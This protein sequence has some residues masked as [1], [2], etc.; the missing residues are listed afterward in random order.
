MKMFFGYLASMMMVL[1]SLFIV[2]I[3]VISIINLKTMG[4]KGI[5]DVRDVSQSITCVD[6]TYSLESGMEDLLDKYSSFAMLIADNGEVVW[7]YAKPVEV[8]DHYD[9]KDVVSFARWYLKDYPV[10]TW[11]SDDGIVVLGLPKKTVWKYPLD[12]NMTTISG[13]MRS[14]PYIIIINAV[15]LILLP[16]L[17]TK[18][19]INLR[20]RSR[21]AWIAGVSH[22]IRTPLS[23]VLASVEKGSVAEKQC[24]KIRDLIGNLNTENK[25]DSGTGK[26]VDEKIALVPL[27]REIVCD[28]INSYGDEYTFEANIDESLGDFTVNADLSL[29]RRMIDN[30]ITNAVLHNDGGCT[31]QVTLEPIINRSKTRIS[32]AKL[33]VSDNGR[34]ADAGKI[35]ALNAGIKNNYLPEHGLGLRVVKEV[36]KKYRY[37]VRFSSNQGSFFK[38]EI[39][40]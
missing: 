18:H 25:L 23:L 1:V 13:L 6:G 2:D 20:E 36:A 40:F 34:G 33:T 15:I 35:K 29:I 7:E 8:P 10:Y 12:F 5:L 21:T 37:P 22:D 38:C 39:Y 3:A 28:Y 26:W 19:W 4:T 11:A 30:L 27:L 24:F 16:I 31:I 17:I 9:M 14:V 32:G